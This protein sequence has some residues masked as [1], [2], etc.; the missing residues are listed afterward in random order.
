MS[1][2]TKRATRSGPRGCAARGRPSA[3]SRARRGRSRQAG[4]EAADS[5]STSAS[6][7]AATLMKLI[8]ALEDDDDVQTVWGNYEVSDEVMEKLADG[9]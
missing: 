5:R 8:D 3:R 7:D 6:D 1:R 2:A 9:G 4:L